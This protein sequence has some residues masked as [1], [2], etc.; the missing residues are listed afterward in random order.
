[1]IRNNESGFTLIEVMMAVVIF[2]IG[3][4]GLGMMQAHFAA[5]NADSRQL[6]RATDI[7]SNQIETLANIS[8]PGDP[9]LNPNTNPHTLTVNSY[10]LNYDVSWDVT[11]NGDQTRTIDL[12][13][14]W[15]T[16]DQNHNVSLRWIKGL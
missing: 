3:L 5:G 2:S 10:P 1:M 11:D 15:T 8:D 13:V 16:G 7:A 12:T 14:T 6:I 9:A 4:L